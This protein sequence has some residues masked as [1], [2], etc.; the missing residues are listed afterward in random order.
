M[1]GDNEVVAKNTCKKCGAT[2]EGDVKFCP[3][4]GAPVSKNETSLKKK[5][6]KLLIALLIIIGIGI[7]AGIGGS[8]SDV[9]NINGDVD[10][11]KYLGN[12]VPTMES[13]LGVSFIDMTT[14]MPDDPNF[15]NI[16]RVRQGNTRLFDCVIDASG[17]IIEIHLGDSGKKGYS[18][19]G[20]T[21]KMDAETATSIW[22]KSGIEQITSS[23]WQ[24][25]NGVDALIRK[26]DRWVLEHD[27]E[28]LKK[29]V[30]ERDARDAF[31]FQFE[32]SAGAYYIGNGQ[33]VEYYY[34]SF[35]AVVYAYK[36]LTGY[37]AEALNSELDGRY[38]VASGQITGVSNTG[39]IDVLC[40]DPNAAKEGVLAL[41]MGTARVSLIEVQQSELMGLHNGDNITVVGRFDGQSRG[42]IFADT[43]DLYDGI[44]LGKEVPIIERNIPGLTKYSSQ[45]TSNGPSSSIGNMLSVS[46]Y[47]GEWEDSYSQRCYMNID[48]YSA[49]G[50]N[51]FIEIHWSDSASESTYWQMVAKYNNATGE[52][53]YSECIRIDSV[54]T[55]DGNSSEYPAYSGGTGKFYFSDGYLHWQDDV[56]HIGDNCLFEKF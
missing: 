48:S 6:H 36:Q 54:Y 17:K 12:T 44:I 40:S 2:I 1:N 49:N 3:N 52:I 28:E 39:K 51:Y 26:S 35:A 13:D 46:D 37:Q 7:V 29:A 9:A 20:V 50:Y 4:C 53:E 27:S 32:D 21:S 23:L 34:D 8:D 10:L 11:A 42:G 22:E 47:Y 41:P 19:F 43:F 45:S 16:Y 30:L 56:E 24:C 31:S 33:I 38:I 18:L 25:N 5:G 15:Q 55:E 14:E